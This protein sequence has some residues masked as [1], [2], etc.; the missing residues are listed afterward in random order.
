MSRL[1][2]RD[3]VCFARDHVRLLSFWVEC[4]PA[5]LVERS[6]PWSEHRRPR[7]LCRGVGASKPHPW[8][9]G[10]PGGVNPDAP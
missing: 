2:T 4:P 3:N 5:E 6:A 9:A 10:E 7:R 8:R 1:E